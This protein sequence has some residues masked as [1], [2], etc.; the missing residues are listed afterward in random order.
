LEEEQKKEKRKVKTRENKR[1]T[2]RKEKSLKLNL[3]ALLNLALRIL[4]NKRKG[5]GKRSESFSCLSKCPAAKVKWTE[6]SRNFSTKSK[7]PHK[8]HCLL[9]IKVAVALLTKALKF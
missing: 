8:I 7:T 2:R 6:S 3:T 5:R 4:R 1:R 9:L